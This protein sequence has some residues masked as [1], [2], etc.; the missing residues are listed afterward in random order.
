MNPSAENLARWFYHSLK[1][2]FIERQEIKVSA[3]TLKETEHFSVRY[4][5]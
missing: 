2:A 1:K 3:V 4:S 5:E